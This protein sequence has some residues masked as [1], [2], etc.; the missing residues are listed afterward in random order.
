MALKKATKVK[1]IDCEYHK[2]ITVNENV[3]GGITNVTLGVYVNKE[4]RDAGVNNY[5]ET[6]NVTV[7]GKDLKMVEIYPLIKTGGVIDPFT[8]SNF[9]A[10][11]VDC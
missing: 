4:A 8:G 11:A 7:K 5:L 6:K 3:L 9:Y 10:D 2:I 1:G